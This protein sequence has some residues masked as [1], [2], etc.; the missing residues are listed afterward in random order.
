MTMTLH[1]VVPPHPL[2][3]HWLSILRIRSTPS[4]I[5]AT[6]LEQLGKCFQMVAQKH[7]TIDK[8]FRIVQP[9]AG[10]EAQEDKEVRVNIP[11]FNDYGASIGKWMDYETSKFDVR[12]VA[13]A[14]LPL[15]RWALLE[16][17]FRWFQAGLIDDIAMIAE[18]DIRNKKQLVERKSLYSQLQSQLQSMEEAIKDKDLTQVADSLTDILYVTYGA[19]IAFGIDLDKCFDEVQKSNMS[20]LGADGKPIYNEKGKVMK[21]PNYFEPDLKKFLKN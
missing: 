1:V 15:N 14:T 12:I 7:Y 2:I 21:G 4:A 5:Y 6:A 3:G 11:I 17:Y 20:K 19:G 13:G 8:V 18:T 10:Q 9:E 16:E